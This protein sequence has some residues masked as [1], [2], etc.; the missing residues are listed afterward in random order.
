MSEFKSFDDFLYEQHNG[1]GKK[2]G[3]GIKISGNTEKS[4]VKMPETSLQDKPEYPVKK[5][6]RPR[7]FKAGG[8]RATIYCLLGVCLV[9]IAGLLVLPISLGTII[10]SGSEKITLED[11]LFEGKIQ[12]PVN[13][14]KVNTDDLQNALSKD[15]RV[16]SVDVYRSFPLTI[17]VDIKDRV[18]VAILQGEFSYAYIDKD[19]VVLETAQAIHEVKVPLITGMKM[20]NLILGDQVQNNEILLA[21]TFLN[22]LTPNGLNVFSEINIGNDKNIRAY[23]RDG[24]MVRLGEGENIDKQA[25]LAENMVGDVRARGLSVE[26]IDANFASPFIKL[27]K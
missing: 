8:F 17:H 22:N 3:T 15:L 11:V 2:A 1:K 20:G 12:E 5:A 24:I 10:L 16:A 14:L 26:Y 18:P 25:K 13:V 9:L 4:A 23:T 7:K 19:G 21:L 27:K 6:G